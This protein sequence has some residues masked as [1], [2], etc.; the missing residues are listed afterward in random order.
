MF[1]EIIK[2]IIKDNEK[3]GYYK[4]FINDNNHIEKLINI[5][6]VMNHLNIRT[7]LTYLDLSSQI[8]NIK[9]IQKDTDF[10]K[11]LLYKLVL[12]IIAI[13]NGNEYML[14]EYYINANYDKYK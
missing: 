8:F 2:S 11:D 1:G 9:E 3:Y 5:F 4:N 12:V 7:F 6:V 14:Y 10:I 13:I